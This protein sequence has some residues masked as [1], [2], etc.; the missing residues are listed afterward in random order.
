M[1]SFIYKEVLKTFFA[2]F[3][4]TSLFVV[5]EMN[6]CTAMD[7]IFFMMNMLT[8]AEDTKGKTPIDAPHE[9]AEPNMQRIHRCFR[10]APSAGWIKLNTDVPSSALTSQVAL[11]RQR[12]DR[13][14]RG[15]C[16]GRLGIKTQAGLGNDR[17]I[18]EAKMARTDKSSVQ[19]YYEAKM[20]LK[21]LR[22]YRI[23]HIK[24][25]SNQAADALAKLARSSGGCI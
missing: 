21:N 3:P 12:Q 5:V 15:G 20:M 1:C 23:A 16:P 8:T 18:L 14:T 11:E 17:I 24:T 9:A 19:S 2:L 10:T 6:T 7:I 25:A 22:G 13:P 4:V